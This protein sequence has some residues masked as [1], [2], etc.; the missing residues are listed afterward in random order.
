MIRHDPDDENAGTQTVNDIFP[1]CSA[2]TLDGERLAQEPLSQCAS[3]RAN[4]RDWGQKMS[5]FQGIYQQV[6]TL[7]GKSGSLFRSFT[8]P[9]QSIWPQNRPFDVN[10]ALLVSCNTPS[11]AHPRHI[12][13]PKVQTCLLSNSSR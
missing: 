2:G 11:Y 4:V 5:R 1:T 3:F 9:G 7:E 13:R 10:L 8:V 12:K 6:L